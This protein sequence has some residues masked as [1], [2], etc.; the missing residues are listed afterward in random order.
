MET[1]RNKNPTLKNLKKVAKALE[2]SVDDLIN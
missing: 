1:G 2:I